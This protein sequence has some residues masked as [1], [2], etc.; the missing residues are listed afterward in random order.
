MAL[1][2]SD[3]HLP[4]HAVDIS[5]K[6]YAPALR[7]K[8]AVIEGTISAGK[9]T[10][11]RLLIEFAKKHAIK[12]KV[13]PEPL[14]PS[15]LKLF[16]EDPKKYA[17]AF[18]LSMLTKRQAIYRE[19]ARYAKDGYFCIIDR[20]LYGDYCFALLHKNSG[21][22]SSDIEW[23]VYLDELKSEKF[24]E[25]DY[26]LYLRISPTVSMERIAK[27]NREGE[28]GYTI[29]YITSLNAVYDS[30][31]PQSPHKQYIVI[32]WN[33]DRDETQICDGLLES[34]K[35]AYDNM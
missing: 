11:S 15:L 22:I 27:R 7:G 34:I 35:L 3:S 21:N 5:Y 10:A 23:P 28:D 9:S 33:K 1:N 29:D 30:I 18:Q 8:I 13:F 32:D 4:F 31:I 12:T 17:F 24:A 25:P 20:S 19:A 2:Q 14:M 26:L 16:L 6:K